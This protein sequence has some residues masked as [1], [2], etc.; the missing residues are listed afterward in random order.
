M[1][2]LKTLHDENKKKYRKNKKNEEDKK[3]CSKNIRRFLISRRQLDCIFYKLF[4]LFD[5]Y[6]ICGLMLV[7]NFLEFSDNALG[8]LLRMYATCPCSESAMKCR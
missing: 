5:L 1:Q 6:V 7:Y 3:R 4:Q 2:S 8:D